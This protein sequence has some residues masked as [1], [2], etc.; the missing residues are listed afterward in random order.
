MAVMNRHQIKETKAVIQ[1]SM[2][3]GMGHT[4]R[5]IKY[6]YLFADARSL[7]LKMGKMEYLVS[8]EP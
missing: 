8:E 7:A 6:K 1:L 3:N 4:A 2:S 5:S